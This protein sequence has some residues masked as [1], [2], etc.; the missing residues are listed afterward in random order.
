MGSWWWRDGGESQ[1][2]IIPHNA[3]CLNLTNGEAHCSAL[4]FMWRF[5]YFFYRSGEYYSANYAN[6][7]C[8]KT[9]LFLCGLWFHIQALVIAQETFREKVI[10]DF[11]LVWLV[12]LTK[13]NILKGQ[14]QCNENCFQTETLWG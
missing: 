12:L 13:N 5:F 11:N 4:L 3:S 2:F 9:T 10:F 7:F 6:I 1:T 14:C 8:R